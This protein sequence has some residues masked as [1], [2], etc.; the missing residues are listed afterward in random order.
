MI[1]CLSRHLAGLDYLSVG[2]KAFAAA[3]YGTKE[4]LELDNLIRGCLQRREPT[5]RYAKEWA[6]SYDVSADTVER[7]IK[8]IKRELGI[9]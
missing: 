7:A 2:G 3:V 5:R 6:A 9:T 8:R 1:R 4:R